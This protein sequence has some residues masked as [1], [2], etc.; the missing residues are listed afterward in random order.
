MPG[1]TGL[2]PVSNGRT[3]IEAQAGYIPGFYLS[4]AVQKDPNGD[5]MVQFSG[6]F[7]PGD[8]LPIKGLS[9]GARYVTGG[10]SSSIIE[11]MLRYRRYLDDNKRIAMQI[12]GFGTTAEG[13][14][15]GASYSAA[16]GGLEF[17]TD[18]RVT[19]EFKWIEFHVTGGSS[20]TLISAEGHYCMNGEGY[21][22]SCSEGQEATTSVK[23]FGAYPALFVGAYLDF[24]RHTDW[25]LHNA[26]LGFFMAGGKMPRVRSGK[27]EESDGSWHSFGLN[28]IVGFG[29]V[30]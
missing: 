14:A 24:F 29:A 7:D 10:D 4:D 11:P 3:G 18:I 22:Q 25:T 15:E 19:P 28:L 5:I 30:K 8:W 1:V 21:G 23:T 12:T 16:R 17:S 2:S 13:R 27:Q 6:M 9:V 26:R 20:L